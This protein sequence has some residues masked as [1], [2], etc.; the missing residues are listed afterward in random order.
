M[1]YREEAPAN[2]MSRRLGYSLIQPYLALFDEPR[3]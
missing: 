2:E 3:G 1:M